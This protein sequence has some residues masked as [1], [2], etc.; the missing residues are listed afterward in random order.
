VVFYCNSGE[1]SIQGQAANIG[2]GRLRLL[3]L[4]RQRVDHLVNV[5]LS[6]DLKRWPPEIAPIWW[7]EEQVVLLL[8]GSGEN[9]NADSC[10]FPLGPF[11]ALP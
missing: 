5:R 6:W 7:L 4:A 8:R 10:S 3:V 2:I 11:L 9:P 1:R